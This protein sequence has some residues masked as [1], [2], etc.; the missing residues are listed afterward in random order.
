MRIDK[1]FLIAK[2]MREV[3]WTKWFAAGG[4]SG[5]DDLER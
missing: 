2:P 4:G 1:T 5:G 3:S